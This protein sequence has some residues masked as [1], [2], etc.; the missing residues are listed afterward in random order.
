MT[1]STITRLVVMLFAL[2]LLA[3]GCAKKP[4]AEEPAMMEAPAVEMQQEAPAVVVEESVTEMAPAYDAAAVA[5]AAEL[6]AAKG[7]E[8]IHFDFDQYTLTEAAKATLVSNAGLLRAAPKVNVLIEG[9]CDERGSDEYNLALGE[10][11]AL[12]T[13]NYL[14]SLGVSVGQLNVISYGE[15]MPIDPAHNVDA[16]AKNRRAAFKVKR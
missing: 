1:K 9:H 3:S 10:K 15:E 2:T 12:A 4:V 14:V 16:W 8:M 13:K 11:R 6:A 5:K 7:L